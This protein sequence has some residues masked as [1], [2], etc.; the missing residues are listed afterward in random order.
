M[1]FSWQ[2]LARYIC[3]LVHIYIYSFLK[4]LCSGN[5]FVLGVT[6]MR[7][8]SVPNHRV[9]QLFRTHDRRA[10]VMFIHVMMERQ[11]KLRI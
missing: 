3:Y 10:L 6:E 1:I 2:V 8:F 5:Y 7:T 9:L 11:S 4:P